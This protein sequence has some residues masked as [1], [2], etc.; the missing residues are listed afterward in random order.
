MIGWIHIRIDDILLIIINSVDVI[1]QDP[2][3]LL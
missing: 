2:H 3:L 1:C